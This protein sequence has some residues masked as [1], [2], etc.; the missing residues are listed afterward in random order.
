MLV[1]CPRF[2]P[3]NRGLLVGAV[4]GLSRPDVP[5]FARICKT[6]PNRGPR[7]AS[8]GTQAGG[9]TPIYGGGLRGGAIGIGLSRRRPRVR[10]PSTPPT[11]TISEERTSRFRR[12]PACK[13]A[14]V[15]LELAI[16]APNSRLGNVARRQTSDLR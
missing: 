7:S 8:T 10:V 12:E 9:P 1:A 11:I 13:Q 3:S 2:E 14:G 16:L 15:R 4:R 5:P 6:F